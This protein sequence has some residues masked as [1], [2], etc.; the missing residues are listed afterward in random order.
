MTPLLEGTHKASRALGPRAKQCLRKSLDQTDLQVLEGLLRRRGSGVAHCGE[1]DTGDRGT[2]NIRQR[3]LSWRPPFWQRPG[4]TQQP[5]GSSAG[6]PQAKQPAKQEHSPTH[7]Q[8]G[9]LKSP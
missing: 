3:E 5:A 1:K 2:G 4:P 6:T 9:C 8:I 7:Q